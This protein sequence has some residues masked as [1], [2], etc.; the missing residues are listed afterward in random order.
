[1]LEPESTFFLVGRTRKHKGN[2]YAAGGWLV[3]V[4]YWLVFVIAHS[5]DLGEVKEDEGRSSR[6][7]GID[8]KPPKPSCG[9]ITSRSATLSS[10]A[11]PNTLATNFKNENTSF[12][13]FC[14][15]GCGGGVRGDPPARGFDHVN[16]ATA[17]CAVRFSR[18]Q[19][20][21]WW[22]PLEKGLPWPRLKPPDS[23]EC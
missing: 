20:T 2:S 9:T 5:S 19:A 15:E 14:P 1:M 21:I 13:H 10:L 18:L 4:L 7:G 8:T 11:H 22:L 12:R 17:G 3:D 23:C 6:D 16:L